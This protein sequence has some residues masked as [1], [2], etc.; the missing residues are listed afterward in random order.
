MTREEA[1]LE[2]DATTLRPQDASPE[3][4]A[5][6]QS[7]PVLGTWLEKRT[8]FDESVAAAFAI[9]IP[10]GLRE[11]IFTQARKPAKRSVRWVLPALISA[12]AAVAL[13]WT[14]WGPVSDEMPGW[15]AES[16]A[17]VA[18][19][20]DGMAK[21]DARAGEL[22]AV[23]KLLA[24]A[25]A[26]SPQHLPRAISKLPTYGCRYIKVAGRKATIICF[27]LDDGS[28]AH[29]VVM[30]RAQLAATQPQF[31]QSKIWQMASW[32]DGEQSFLLATTASE[33]VLKKLFELA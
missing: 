7:D 23:K 13:G 29:L 4:R 2:L 14:L 22:D 33:A 5:L 30:D 26:P 3:A 24:A 25:N 6:A 12:A 27:K 8:E 17:A 15:K 20:H 18:K 16:L 1:Q 32:S 28:T 19:I 31:E 21:L 10:A 9:S 11:S